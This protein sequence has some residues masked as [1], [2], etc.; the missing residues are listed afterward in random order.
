M[1][2]RHNRKRGVCGTAFVITVSVVAFSTLGLPDPA[3]ATVIIPAPSGTTTATP[4]E[5][6]ETVLNPLGL[7]NPNDVFLVSETEP[8]I[9]YNAQNVVVFEGT[10]ESSVYV[11]PAEPSFGGQPGLDFVYQ[12]TN[13]K[14][15]MTPDD[16]IDRLTLA[17]FATYGTDVDYIG[18]T[19]NVAPATADRSA[20][21]GAIIGFNFPTGGMVAPGSNTDYLVVATTDVTAPVQGTASVIDGGSGSTGA[22]AP[23]ATVVFTVPEPAT[24]GLLSIAGAMLLGRRRR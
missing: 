4:T 12:L 22:E 14:D 10:V 18:G 8:F 24:F 21:P 23:V 20:V 6:S 2:I 13:S 16:P 9:G 17:S 1:N 5:L 11:D 7:P 3:H 19:G 15:L